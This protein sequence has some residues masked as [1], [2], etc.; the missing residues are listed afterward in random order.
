MSL[1]GHVPTLIGAL[2]FIAI[3][4]AMRRIPRFGPRGWIMPAWVLIPCLLAVFELRSVYADELYSVYQYFTAR[5]YYG[6]AYTS[7]SPHAIQAITFTLGLVALCAAVALELARARF[8]AHCPRCLHRLLPSQH[9][10]P[11]CGRARDHE[12]G[13]DSSRL[14]ALAVRRPL[15]A[16]IIQFA[17]MSIPAGT[18]VVLGITFLP[19]LRERSSV[20]ENP[21]FTIEGGRRRGHATVTADYG[22]SI[23]PMLPGAGWTFN[24][25]MYVRYSMEWEGTPRRS[26]PDWNTA[27]HWHHEDIVIGARVTSACDYEKLLKTL[28]EAPVSTIDRSR[29]QQYIESLLETFL[30]IPAADIPQTPTN[31]VWNAAPETPSPYLNGIARPSDPQPGSAV[32]PTQV[33][34]HRDEYWPAAFDP[35]EPAH[36]RDSPIQTL[37]IPSAIGLVASLVLFWPQRRK[38]AKTAQE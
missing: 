23:A 12:S 13:G 37:V 14:D 27:K 10:C 16:W 33:T 34:A 5:E 25:S 36:D 31:V 4:F 21:L 20:H 11:E 35:L 1:I 22:L 17:A 3:A 6:S 29:S 8:G 30:Q 15:I 7:A 24:R 18:L 38:A 2:A 9:A 28:D 26:R 19:T 32:A